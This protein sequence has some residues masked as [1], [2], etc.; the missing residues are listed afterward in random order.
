[1]FPEGERVSL[2]LGP[3][4]V[5]W[6]RTRNKGN[7]FIKHCSA[8]EKNVRCAQFVDEKNVPV[9]PATEAHVNENGTLDIGSFRATDVGEYFSPDELERVHFNKDGTFWA[10]PRSRISVVLE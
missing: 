1:M 7:E 4:I 2:D 3:N 10:L 9:L 5:T 8:F 6:G